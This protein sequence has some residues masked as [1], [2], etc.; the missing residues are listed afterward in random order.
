MMVSTKYA[1]NIGLCS[2]AY[3]LIP[4]N[5]VIT[6]DV[7]KP[8]IFVTFW[9]MRELELVLL[10]CCKLPWSS[11]NFFNGWLSKPDKCKEVL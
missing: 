2:A 9:I 7:T 11:Q 10:F 5:L 1:L 4:V 8:Y 3:E 6:V